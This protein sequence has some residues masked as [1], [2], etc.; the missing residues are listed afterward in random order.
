MLFVVVLENGTEKYFLRN[1]DGQKHNNFI[2]KIISSN[3]ESVE[4]P[5][6]Y[7]FMLVRSPSTISNLKIV[8]P[9]N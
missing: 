6:G 8:I 5:S 3:I 1:D 7:S 2:E 9:V 4:C